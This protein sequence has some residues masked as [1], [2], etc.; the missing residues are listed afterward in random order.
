MENSNTP[1]IYEF[2]TS[3]LSQDATI[4]YILAWAD[5]KYRESHPRLHALGTKLLRSLLWTQEVDLPLIETLYVETQV[6]RIDILVQINTDKNTNRIILLIEDKVS[7]SEHSN[8]IERYK[9]TAEEI[10]S[11]SY[12]HLVAVYLKTGN[13]SKEELP[14]KDK[15]GH[16]L[17]RDLLD[18]LNKFQDTKNVIV[19]D[20][21]THLQ[22]WEDDANRKRDS[23]VSRAKELGVEDLFVDIE[24][25]FK[26]NW[27]SPTQRIYDG[28]YLDLQWS[29]TEKPLSARIDLIKNVIQIV[30]FPDA[31][32]LCV[33]E[34]KPLVK[35][36]PF[37]TWRQNREAEA[38]NDLTTALERY[39]EIQ[40]QLTE[41]DW[42]THKEKL[43]RLTLAVY[44][45]Q[46]SRMQ[47][48]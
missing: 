16:F 33:D 30:F 40:F 48:D 25:M 10:Y 1:N 32:G 46:Q 35:E 18:V 14:P 45:A 42:E 27:H 22:R 12:D 24:K 11:G 21:R 34:F 17:R 8:Q 28:L 4:A 44:D 39:L 6:K 7:T 26:E 29:K 15:C 13:T 43:N 47:G 41:A 2:A 19:D 20:F 5:P 37:K 36:I 3:E 31:I 38:K 23:F 9:E